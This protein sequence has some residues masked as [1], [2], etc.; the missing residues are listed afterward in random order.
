MA[1]GIV[2]QIDYGLHINALIEEE[3]EPIIPCS[4]YSRLAD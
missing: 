2:S 4:C 1:F 3:V